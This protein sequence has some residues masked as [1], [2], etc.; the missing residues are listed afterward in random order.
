LGRKGGI[1]FGGA[2]GGKPPGG[3][4][5]AGG[6]ACTSYGNG[7]VAYVDRSAWLYAVQ[8]GVTYER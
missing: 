6:L 2:K 3:R 5:G 1:P 4:N 8:D 7:R